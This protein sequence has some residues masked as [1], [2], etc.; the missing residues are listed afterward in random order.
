MSL[1]A[2][3]SAAAAALAFVLVLAAWAIGGV[4]VDLPWAPALGLRLAFELDGLGILYSLLATGIGLAVIVYSG[5]YVPLHL[6]HQGRP[7]R[8]E[9]RFHGFLLLFM[10]SMIGLV[11][12]QDLI[13]LFVFWDLT[14]IASYF[15]IGYD[16]QEIEARIAGLMA[17]VV[18][19]V[20]AVLLLIGIL[21]LYVEY[22]TFSLPELIER[23]EPGTAVT[24][25]AGLMAVAGLAKSAQVPFQFWLPRAMAA[26]TPVSAYLHAAA[27]VAAGVFLLGRVYPLL[28]TSE[29]LLNGLVAVG[30]ASMFVGG[31]LALTRD[32]LKQLL[33]YSTI[34]QYGYVVVLY[35]LGGPVGAVGASFYVIA[36]A[37]AKSALFLAAG[38][39]T[40]A[41]GEERL[42]RLGGL[43]Q[44]MPVLAVASG[45]AAAGLAA[46]PLTIGFF[47]DELFFKAALERSTA[48]SVLTVLGAALTFA[49][50]GRFWLGV[51][52]GPLR[53]PAHPV[54]ALLV[55]PI[56]ALGGLVL[57]GGLYPEPFVR[58]ANAAAEAS[59]GTATSVDVAYHL[60]ARAENVMAVLAYAAGA[61]ILSSQRV[62]QG[63]AQAFA[64]LG[65]RIGPER[66]YAA[67]IR[68]LNEFS[69]RIHGIEVRD[70]RTRIAA[71]LVPGGILML[72]GLAATPTTGSYTPGSLDRGDIALVLVLLTAALAAV[73]TTLPRQHLTLLLVAASVGFSLAVVYAFL[74][75]PNVAL[76][77]A[78]VE[79]TFTL[80]FIGIFALMPRASLR[81]L[82][83]LRTPAT[84]RWRDPL[85]GGAAALGAFLVVWGALSRPSVGDSVAEEHVRLTP[86]AHAKDIV[87]AI[88]TDFRGLDTLG[89]IT[90][91]AIAFFGIATLLRRGRLW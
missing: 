5:G 59:L 57:V 84:R 80:L 19:G 25:A 13:L 22:G 89:E 31:V 53:S 24:V 34:S 2:R 50:I 37:L 68:G 15:L 29:A 78:L 20:T 16:R 60:D 76:V 41:T 1:L 74:G 26:P 27:M 81:R 65:E 38:A 86:D 61:L 58:L 4:S 6:A 18:T 36:H 85:I 47:K 49:Y 54:T 72:L 45:L 33:A 7:P 39:V 70:L 14:A 30:F 44:P 75:G 52:L 28:E 66:I 9:V 51:F 8:D 21:I 40:E 77:A 67:S 64:S 90:V 11:T 56:A 91:V 73:A 43:R 82:A 71:I 87:T 42:S 55:A 83:A 79:T 12:A 46:L 48:V 32:R 62:W 3:L 17:L 63:A 23:A 69:D 35:G 88:L 10:V